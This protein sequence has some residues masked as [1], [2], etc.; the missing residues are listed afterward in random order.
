MQLGRIDS[1][2]GENGDG[3]PE[4]VLRRAEE[5]CGLLCDPSER[6][7]AERTMRLRMLMRLHLVH[8]FGCTVRGHD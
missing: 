4:D 1:D 6:I 5:P 7:V 8:G 2:P 3:L